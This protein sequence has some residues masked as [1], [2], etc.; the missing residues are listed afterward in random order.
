HTRQHGPRG[1]T[2]HAGNGDLSTAAAGKQQHR[3]ARQRRTQHDSTH[4]IGLLDRLGPQARG[5]SDLTV[6]RPA[7][8]VT[9]RAAEEPVKRYRRGGPVA[10]CT[11]G[12]LQPIR[13]SSKTALA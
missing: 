13:K 1:V 7:A 4:H 10:A 2:Y 8:K 9:L 6:G 12:S 11:G 5:T 3:S